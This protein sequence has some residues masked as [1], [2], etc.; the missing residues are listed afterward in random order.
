MHKIASKFQ[1][2]DTELDQSAHSILTGWA[3]IQ[4]VFKISNSFNLIALIVLQF[5]FFI[6]MLDSFWTPSHLTVNKEKGSQLKKE[7]DKSPNLAAWVIIFNPKKS[8][9]R[10]W[11]DPV[12]EFVSLLS[13][14]FRILS[15]RA[16]QHHKKINST[17]SDLA[18]QL[19]P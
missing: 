15:D 19:Q 1:V 13:A 12:E 18:T 7:E 4:G 2:I 3:C 11:Y 16:T 5:C 9:K 10:F 6:L 14:Y 8:A 17:S